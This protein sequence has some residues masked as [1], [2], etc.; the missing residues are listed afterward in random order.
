MHDNEYLSETI[1]QLLEQGEPLVLAAIIDQSGSTPRQSGSKMIVG[2]QDQICGTIGGGLLEV[3]ASQQAVAAI[4]N[5]QSALMNFDLNNQDTA[6]AEMI[7][8]GNTTVLLDYIEPSPENRDFFRQFHD[9]IIKNALFYFLTTSSGMGETG[10]QIKHSLLFQDGSTMGD[11]LPPSAISYIKGE[12]HNISKT[13]QLTWEDTM[14]IVDPFRRTK[15]LYCLGAGHVA[16]PTAHLAALMGFRV[17][18]IDDRSEFANTDRFP[19]A[20]EVH[21][22]DDFNQ[23]FPSTGI[24][25][26]GFIAIFTR[27]HLYDRLVLEQALKTQAGYIGLMA[28]RR[29]REIVYQAI[30]DT[31]VSS[32]EFDR[33]HCPIGIPLEAETPEELAVSIVG[34][35]INERARQL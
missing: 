14:I 29:K 25:E 9:T 2:R 28:S 32:V 17:V 20:A 19:E 22:I 30:Q 3:T 6:S 24:D 4:A 34:E 33:V 11:T 12:L 27:G 5:Q 15:T 1:C 31:G 23:A 8:G 21:V 13:A 18:V 26:D 16:K 10:L 7:C 35:L